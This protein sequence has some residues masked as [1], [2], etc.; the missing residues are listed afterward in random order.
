MINVSIENIYHVVV[1]LGSIIAFIKWIYNLGYE[2]GKNAK[3]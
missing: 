2:H 1:I 3:K